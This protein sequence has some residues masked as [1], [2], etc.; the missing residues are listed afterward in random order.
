M[1][2]SSLNGHADLPGVLRLSQLLHWIP[3]FPGAGELL[4]P[5]GAMSLASTQ[6]KTHPRTIEVQWVTTNLMKSEMHI[7]L[8]PY[9][10]YS[11]HCLNCI[12][13]HRRK[14]SP[15]KLSNIGEGEREKVQKH[16]SQTKRSKAA[17]FHLPPSGDPVGHGEAGNRP[18]QLASMQETAL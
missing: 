16:K 18:C 1:D 6:S 11:V 14:Q 10:I 15:V 5:Y 17:Q 12:N 3:P 8:F 7:D 2:L 9:P 13:F 4:F